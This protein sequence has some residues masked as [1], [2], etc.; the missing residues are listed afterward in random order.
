LAASGALREVGRCLR[1]LGEI[2]GELQTGVTLNISLQRSLSVVLGLR[3]QEFTQFWAKILKQASEAQIDAVLSAEETQ[4][5]LCVSPLFDSQFNDD[6]VER[7]G[8]ESLSDEEC[9]AFERITAK[10][11]ISGMSTRP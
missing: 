6:A 10:L 8:R 5:A 7:A 4:D 2:S 1:L 11:T 9:D 3:P